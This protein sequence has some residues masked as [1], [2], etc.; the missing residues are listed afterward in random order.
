M[1]LSTYALLVHL[2]TAVPLGTLVC[3]QNIYELEDMY[4]GNDF[5][6]DWS[7]FTGPDPTNGNGNAFVMAV[8]STS[9]VPAGGNRNS[10]R[11]TSNKQYN[12]GLFILDVA[13]MPVGCGTWPSIWTNGPNWPAGGEIDI[14]E[15]I[16]NQPNNQMTL[17]SGTTNACTLVQTNPKSFTGQV[18]STNCYSTPSSDS[19]CSIMDTTAN[20]FGP[21]FNSVGGGVFAFLWDA[22]AG[23]SM[24]HF[25]RGN[26]PGDIT[27]QTPVPTGWGTPAGFWSADNCDISDNFY[28]HSMIID[29]TLC[30]SW[31]GPAYGNSH[32]PGTCAEMIANAA[33]FANA[34]WII[35]Y[36][37]V[38]QPM[39]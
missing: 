24:W 17:H 10:V 36:I 37:A 25:A 6:S 9:N 16:N 15:G 33:N 30:G 34:K 4:Q 18:L 35:N 19:G 3:A 29:T 13:A 1:G 20:S 5:F 21:G 14:V 23:M 7:F 2:L 12:G 31:A 32:C 8:D 38:Y 26:I 22:S 11:I 27:A 28:D 39:I